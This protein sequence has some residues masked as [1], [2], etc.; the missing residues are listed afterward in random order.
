MFKVITVNVMLSLVQVVSLVSK[1]NAFRD[2]FR[3]GLYGK[4]GTE[5]TGKNY[6]PT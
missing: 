6:L 4:G 2:V 5:S 1:L 3:L